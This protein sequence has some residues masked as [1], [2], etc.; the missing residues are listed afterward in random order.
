MGKHSLDFDW[1]FART[2]PPPG[3]LVNWNLIRGKRYSE[4]RGVA[5]VNF[6]NK[7]L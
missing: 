5:C 1:L 6:L 2:E 7:F 3:F 4:L